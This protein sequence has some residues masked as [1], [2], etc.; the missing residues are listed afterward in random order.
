[1]NITALQGIAKSVRA[2][3]IDAIQKA[4]SGHPGLPLGAAELGAVLFGE[5]LSYAPGDT[6]WPNRDRFV[7]SAGHG[8]AL[9]YSLLFLSGQA[10]SLEDLKKFRQLDS[11]TP[12]H[13][14]YGRTPGVETT[15]G[16]LGAGLSSL[17][18]MAIAQ[19][20]LAGR[21]N[22]PEHKIIDHW[23]FALAGDGCLMEGV[24]S[25]A[26]SLAGHLG[27]GKIIV[28]YDSNRI[29]IEGSTELAFT[30]DVPARYRAYGWQTLEGD[31]YDMPGI[32]ALIQEAKRDTRRPALIKLNSLIGKGAATLEGSHKVH[33]S[34]LGEA[35]IRATRKKLGIPED[36]EFFV[37]PLALE[38]FAQRNKLLSERHES[39]KALFEAWSRANPELRKEWDQ[40][41]SPAIS[42]ETVAFPDFKTGDS[43]AT[44]TAGGKVLTAL[45]E[46]LPQLTGG[47]ADLAPSNNTALPAFG[48][49][50]VKNPMGRTLH[51]G[52]REHAMGGIMNGM[53]VYGG[54]RVFGATFLVFSDYLRPA[55]RLA[56]LMKLPVIYIFTHDSFYV[57]E[58]G[59]T[60]EPV[61]TLASLRV[62]PGLRVFR[63]GD[64]Q[65]TAEAWKMALEWGD[66]PSVLALTRQNLEVY[67]KA[68][69]DWKANFRRG[70]YLVRDC[71]GTPDVVAA[72]S[73]SEVNLAL[74]AAEELK[75]RKV[76]VVSVP[77][78]ELFYAQPEAYRKKL[79][80]PGVRVVVAEA[81]VAS[82][83]EALASS[84]GDILC[85]KGFGDS[86]PA[87]KLAEVFGFTPGNLAKLIGEDLG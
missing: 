26:S 21:F 5:T 71:S 70:A 74:K 12:G 19:E 47:S 41:F 6:L 27:L 57:G 28:F 29:T 32:A 50:S 54:F 35:E 58:D 77:N 46:K 16:P 53:A 49:F 67:E 55:I 65:E 78:R 52:I 72:A 48:D 33:G 38:Y 18:G 20:M 82:G 62:I 17:V 37:D 8:S 83:W 43:L 4:N 60:H 73:G 75:G 34:P 84:P 24:A 2:L 42:L 23:L 79:F 44:R 59:P 81:G 9:L 11:L 56:A 45:A 68:D 66:A 76:R 30:E 61:E 31:A 7:L 85:M 39:W 64:A 87:E 63:P 40:R 25:E 14:E 13:P 3:S 69:P 15:T 36:Q 80:P 51:F 1:M 86:A 10:L 22:T